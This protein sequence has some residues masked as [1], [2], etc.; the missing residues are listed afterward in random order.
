MEWYAKQSDRW[1]D[2]ACT[3][4]AFW[5][6][7]LIVPGKTPPLWW[8]A[9]VCLAGAVFYAGMAEFKRRRNDSST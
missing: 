5:V 7:D 8:W 4:L 6:A 1:L 9:I 3:L 2:S